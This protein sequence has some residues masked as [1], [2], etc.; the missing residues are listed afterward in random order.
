MG[1]RRSLNRQRSA[2][3]HWEHSSCY[4]KVQCAGLHL[5]SGREAFS[6]KWLII[7]SVCHKRETTT[8]HRRWSVKRNTE[9]AVEPHLKITAAV[10]QRSL[11]AQVR[12]YKHTRAYFYSRRESCRAEVVW[13][14]LLSW[15]GISEAFRSG[16]ENK[17]H[18]D[19]SIRV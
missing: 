5:H 14:N 4:L 19:V 15:R 16:R 1:I 3:R 2:R 11:S 6:P 9:P 13:A 12:R 7:K 8:C 17:I 18:N 10:Y